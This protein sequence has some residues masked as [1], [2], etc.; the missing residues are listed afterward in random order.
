[1][2]AVLPWDDMA[3]MSVFRALDADDLLEAAL[4]RGHH[5]THLALFAEWRAVQAAAPLSVIL[6]TGAGP[7]GGTPFAV[8]LLGNT[9]Q[10]G[11]GQAALLARDHHRFR[12]DLV[13]AARRIRAEMP[14]WC[15][16]RGVHRV[17]AR[18][19]AGHPR[20]GAF[21]RGCGF[22]EECEM[23]GFGGDGA[24]S[25]KQFAWTQIENEGGDVC[26]S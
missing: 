19:W 15:A 3:A 8:M 21:L 14:G 18:S 13:L 5:P 7:A 1:M 2:V 12:R 11:V 4:I 17:E 23:P 6:A 20:A 25:F 26:V 9:G 16:A 10:A 22:R 24:T